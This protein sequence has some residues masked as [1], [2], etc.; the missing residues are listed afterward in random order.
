VHTLGFQIFKVLAFKTQPL[1]SRQQ[2][3]QPGEHR[4]PAVKRVFTEEVIEDCL[5]LL[6][7]RQ[8]IDLPHGQLVLIRVG[9][10]DIDHD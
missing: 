10:R 2:I 9:A 3:L 8:K 7:A 4:V 1:Q 5:L 6:A